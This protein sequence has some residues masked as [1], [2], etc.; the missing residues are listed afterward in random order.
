MNEI[1]TTE[2]NLPAKIFVNFHSGPEYEDIV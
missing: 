1:R 2:L